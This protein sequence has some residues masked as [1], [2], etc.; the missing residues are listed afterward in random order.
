MIWTVNL[1]VEASELPCQFGL[2]SFIRNDRIKLKNDVYNSTEH[3]RHDCSCW[4]VAR[5]IFWWFYYEKGG[6]FFLPTPPSF[7]AEFLCRIW[8]SH[9]QWW[10]LIPYSVFKC[11]V[12]WY[13]CIL[14]PSCFRVD[15]QKVVCYTRLVK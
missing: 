8:E 13:D 12:L 15:F 6:V 7:F 1:L 4:H 11:N 9:C 5:V 2:L 14:C 3:N 10:Q